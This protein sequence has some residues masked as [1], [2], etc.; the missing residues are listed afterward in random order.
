MRTIRDPRY[1]TKAYYIHNDTQTAFWCKKTAA[2]NITTEMGSSMPLSNGHYILETKSKLQFE[3]NQSVVFN[4]EKPLL[5]QDVPERT[6]DTKDL[7][8]M[9]GAPTDIIRMLVK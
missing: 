6:P 4:N 5:I 3:I 7:N 9:R 2:K 1:R 8:E